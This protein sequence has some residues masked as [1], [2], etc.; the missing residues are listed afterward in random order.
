MGLYGLSG[1]GEEFAGFLL[2]SGFNARV[3]YYNGM[4][5]L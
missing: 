2:L 5:V 3:C 1:I 4:D